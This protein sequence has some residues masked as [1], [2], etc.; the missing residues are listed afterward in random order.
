LT[1]KRQAQENKEKQEQFKK[2][3]IEEKENYKKAEEESRKKVGEKNQ[4]R[5]RVKEKPKQK[6]IKLID[7]VEEFSDDEIMNL[8]TTV[9]SSRVPRE[10]R[11][12][13]RYLNGS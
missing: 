13:K 1:K 6:E 7:E 11:A 12:P 9:T 3:K 2:R 8:E 4:K 5:N 10:K